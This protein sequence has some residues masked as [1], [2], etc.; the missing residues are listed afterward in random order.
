MSTRYG[1]EWSAKIVATRRALGNYKLSDEHKEKLRQANLGKKPTRET[2]EK[3]RL[4]RTGKPTSLLGRK[5]STEHREH[6]SE[7]HI[8]L[9]H[10]VDTKIKIAN[11]PNPSKG[12]NHP[13]AIITEAEALEIFQLYG[14]GFITQMELAHKYHVVAEL[15]STSYTGTDGITSPGFP[16][17]AENIKDKGGICHVSPA[18]QC[19][20]SVCGISRGISTT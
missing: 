6:I 2:L 9:N 8:G 5:Y 10:N 18:R 16:L 1:K 3:I 14:S 13:R 4:I 7:G 20:N 15:L 11:R 19:Q 17:G 12:S